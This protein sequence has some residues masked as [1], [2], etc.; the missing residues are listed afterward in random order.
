MVNRELCLEL[1]K[2]RRIE[3]RHVPY[4][5]DKFTPAPLS[6][7]F[8]L[9]SMTHSAHASADIHVRHRWPPV[10]TRP[11]SGK[12]VMFQPWEFGSLPSEWVA[13]LDSIDEIWV[14]TNFLKACYERSSVPQSKVHVIPLGADPDLF[15]PSYPP[16]HWVREESG[17]RFRFLYNGGL[18]ARKGADILVDAYL[19][20]FRDDERVCLVIKRDKDFYKSEIGVKI[21]ELSRKTDSARILFKAQDLDPGDLPGLYTA[22]DC[23]VH[24]YRAEGFGL[25]IAEAMACGI[26]AIVTGG[27]SCRDFTDDTCCYYI[28][29]T[30][31][32]LLQKAVGKIPTV[33]RP[34]WLVPDMKHLQQLMRYAYEH[35]DEV[36]EKGARARALISSNFTWKKSAEAVVSRLLALYNS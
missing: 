32:I 27:G 17:E 20:E 11:A 1:I 5:T 21:E 23:Y 15:H 19:N 10:L 31:E 33:D 35:R 7:L 24:P 3:V 29:C 25:P 16:L 8:P 30:P 14:Y 13:S 2:E 26:P 34:F 18:T 22:C 9:L 4:E 28:N 36:K 12:H 6:R